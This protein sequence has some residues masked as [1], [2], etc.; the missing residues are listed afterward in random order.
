MAAALEFWFQPRTQ[1]S[2]AQNGALRG[3]NGAGSCQSFSPACPQCRSVPSDAAH[4]A[5]AGRPRRPR[6]APLG[7]ALL[8]KS[9]SLTQEGERHHKGHFLSLG[10]QGPFTCSFLQLLWLLARKI[11]QKNKLQLRKKS[12]IL[13][14]CCQREQEAALLQVVAWGGQD[15]ECGDKSRPVH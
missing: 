13:W 4:A 2:S 6:A 10:R 14:M 8:D 11:L 7:V 12:L 9:N 15:T 5:L 1:P 3:V